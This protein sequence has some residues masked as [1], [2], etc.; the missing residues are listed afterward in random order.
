MAARQGLLG[1][2]RLFPDLCV[3][4][5][6]TGPV[7]ALH[8]HCSALPTTQKEPFRFFTP[9]TTACSPGLLHGMWSEL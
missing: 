9:G 8:V 7:G 1:P 3:L 4:R 6:E 5:L 2:L